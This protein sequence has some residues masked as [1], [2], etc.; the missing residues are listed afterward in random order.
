MEYEEAGKGNSW[1]VI[2]KIQV[3]GRNILKQWKWKTKR[4][5]IKMNF[6][7]CLLPL[8]PTQRSELKLRH[9]GTGRVG[10]CNMPWG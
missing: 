3:G 2:T 8:L 5:A 4:N 9:R 1:E 6:A 10:S 7:S